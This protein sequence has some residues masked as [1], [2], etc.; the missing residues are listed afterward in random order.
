MLASEAAHKPERLKQRYG[1]Q[2]QVALVTGGT[3]GIGHAVVDELCALGAQV[4]K[5]TRMWH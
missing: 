1:L 2:G 3:K 4:N 5:F